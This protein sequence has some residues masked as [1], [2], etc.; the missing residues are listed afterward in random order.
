MA[1][2]IGTSGDDILFGTAFD[3]WLDG[4]DGID[5]LNAGDGQ[6]GLSGGIGNDFLYG[7]AGDDWLNGGPG[8]DL[9]DGGANGPNVDTVDY[10]DSPSGVNINLA[11]GTANDGWGGTDTL[12]NIEGVVGSSFD[13][14]LI[15]DGGYNWFRPGAGNDYVDAAGGFDVLFYSDPGLNGVIIDLDAGTAQGLDAFGNVFNDIVLNF[16]AVHGSFGN[17]IIT[18]AIGDGYAFGQAGNDEIYGQAGNNNLIG[19][20]GDDI[21]D[22]GADWDSVDYYDDGND[23]FSAITQG[24]VVDLGAGTATDGWGGTDTLFNIESVGGSQLD[25]VIVGDGN[26]N[27]LT[28][29]AGNDNIDGAVGHDYV[30]GGSGN[31]NLTGGSGNDTL[32]YSE[33]SYWNELPVTQ[34][35]TVNLA[36][37]VAT[38]NWGNTD[39]LSGFENIQGS[40][41][42]DTL[43][44]AGGGGNLIGGDGNDTITG[45]GGSDW[46]YGG[47]GNDNIDGAGGHDYVVGG[48][49]NDDLTGGSG[50]DTVDY[51]ENNYW[52]EL[53]VTQGVTVNLATGVAADNWGD[54]DT[55]SGFENIRGSNLDDTLIGAGGGG[56]LTGGGG[57]DTITGGGGFDW[58]RGDS[59]N[60]SLNGGG[61]Y[62]IASYRY[63]NFGDIPTI[64][65]GIVAHLGA[66]STVIDRWGNTDTLSSIERVDGSHGDDIMSADAGFSGSYGDFTEFQGMGG[67]D[68]ITG[69]GT[70]RISYFSSPDGILA[71]LSLATVTF[72]DPGTTTVA[73]LTVLDGWG[74]TD[75]I[76]SGIFSLHATDYDDYVLG[77]AI[78]EEIQLRGGNDWVDGGSGIDTLRYNAPGSVH[79]NLADG[80]TYNDGWGGV[81]TLLNI[82]NIR[83][84][85]NA[86]MLIGDADDNKL[87]GEGGNDLL[88]GGGGDDEIYGGSGID[89]IEGGDGIDYMLGGSGDDTLTGGSGIGDYIYA[90]GNGEGA[91]DYDIASFSDASGSLVANL[92]AVATVSGAGVGTDTLSHVEYVRGGQFDDIFNVD[93]SFQSSFTNAVDVEGLGGNDEITGNGATRLR[94]FKA[95][96]GVTVDLALGVSYGSDG[97]DSAN[98]GWDTFTGVRGAW[99]SLFDDILL[100]SA[101]DD[102]FR[103]DQGN[104]VIDGRGGIDRVDFVSYSNGVF[105]DLAAGMAQ[106]DAGGIDSLANIENITGSRNADDLNGDGGSNL[107]RGSGGNDV[108]D[109]RTGDDGV[110]GDGGNDTIIDAG[111]VVVINAGDDGH[112]HHGKG[113]DKGKG[114]GH[115][116]HDHDD[117]GHGHGGHDHGKG[118]H[119][120]K[121][122]DDHKDKGKGHDDHKGKGKGQDKYDDDDGGTIVVIESDNDIYT[123]G[124]GDDLF[125]FGEYNGN[126]TIVDFS[127]GAGSEDVID[128]SALNLGS[129]GDLLA[130]ADDNGGTTD[131]TDTTITFSDEGTVTLI[132]VQV[133]DLH[134]DDFII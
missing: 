70:T 65:G 53:P 112:H 101:G 102:Q 37:G 77:S 69:N 81:D 9:L 7:G 133:A 91:F 111:A 45:G 12:I 21:L 49:G 68:T 36:T 58:L 118:H 109:A 93:V 61:G 54:T 42:D 78:G 128:V 63:E 13:D 26:D 56:S 23:G 35:V 99:G 62:D 127:A 6:D 119:K 97:I 4:L 88:Q 20:S 130:L 2:I 98:V 96:A 16:E 100:G 131:T 11:T 66:V 47:A 15:G 105:V 79:V 10:G 17:D 59:G 24:A 85:N 3:D 123:G 87:Q 43:T 41:L 5:V 60:D 129:L 44:G 107:I 48:S 84:G 83:G 94:F 82:E 75:S 34:G 121:G 55:L 1:N 18:L 114:K 67:D 33:N 22:G 125:V 80:I 117:H 32:D 113:H 27:H 51:S 31:D 19:G 50:N 28:G 116:K 73:A 57:N 8:D 110:T 30:V 115:D 76:G 71:N 39:T 126:D 103:G 134:Q 46:L 40:N 122:H 92:G 106:D 90:G 95:E 74:G 38:D 132:G 120:H 29:G 86:D 108:I 25:D 14:V 72:T 124:I 64:N 104:D 52:N 89:V